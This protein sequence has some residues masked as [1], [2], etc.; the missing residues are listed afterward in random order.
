[1]TNLDETPDTGRYRPR[2]GEAP[3]G[4]AGLGNIRGID[5]DNRGRGQRRPG[6]ISET[7]LQSLVKRMRPRP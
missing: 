4:L 2:A 7:V 6:G 3:Q 5:V 1:V